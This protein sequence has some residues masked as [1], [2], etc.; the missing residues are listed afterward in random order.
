MEK[1]QG[2]EVWGT[3][4]YSGTAKK[5]QQGRLW[6]QSEDKGKKLVSEYEVTE[7]KEVFQEK[8]WSAV[9]IGF[10]EIK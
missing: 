2:I 4:N 1:R 6:E 5:K 9:L 3:P 10:W 7:S 8:E